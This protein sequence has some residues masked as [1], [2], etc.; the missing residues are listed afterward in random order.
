MA[1]G[2]ALAVVRLQPSP[3][4]APER[5]LDQV[6]NLKT[7]SQLGAEFSNFREAARQW[8]FV[9]KALDRAAE[10]WLAAYAYVCGSRESRRESEAAI[11]LRLDCLGRQRDA[12]AVVV[13]TLG[14]SDPLLFHSP[15]AVVG[16]LPAPMECSDARALP[17]TEHL[18]PEKARQVLALRARLAR[19]KARSQ[20]TRDGVLEELQAIQK[21]ARELGSEAVEAEANYFEGGHL[22]SIGD[23]KAS[24]GAYRRAIEIAD[25]E[26]LDVLAARAAAT[27]VGNT[28][29]AGGTKEEV[30][31]QVEPARRR[32][33]RAGNSPLAQQAL[34]HSLG[35]VMEIRGRAAEAL[36]HMQRALE[37][38]REISGAESLGVLLEL[39]NL[40]SVYQDL[41][42]DDDSVATL[43]E[44]IVLSDRLVG[45]DRDNLRIVWVNLAWALGDLGRGS[46]AR[47]AAEHAMKEPPDAYSDIGL[48]I[49]AHAS[50]IDGRSQEGLV[51]AER[52]LALMERLKIENQQEG[53]EVLRRCA[54]AYLR[55]GRVS[56][57]VGLVERLLASAKPQLEENSPNWVPFLSVA[58]E[59][60][61]AAR[62]PKRAEE[63][64]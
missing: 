4:R 15:V 57:A 17:L 44:A 45:P 24:L 26:H 31:A 19:I 18:P 8:P 14:S 29:F 34:E 58:G 5:E 13:E 12:F 38:Q 35:S 2:G 55:G 56:D 37:L 6:W 32:V 11:Q 50:V 43:R 20:L 16:T 42:R 46:E 7:R 62:Q 3:C 63:L 41:G 9:E 61:V 1:G 21:E 39:N 48:A 52:A 64:L 33:E 51:T 40:G 47:Q 22:S 49:I 28:A 27:L 25:V 23:T 36:P 53:R 54:I 60:Y 10:R 30:D 59:A